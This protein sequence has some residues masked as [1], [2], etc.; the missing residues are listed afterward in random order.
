[1]KATDAVRQLYLQELNIEDAKDLSET[2]ITNLPNS[3]AAMR[4]A[5]SARKSDE[6]WLSAIHP[7]TAT[8]CSPLYSMKDETK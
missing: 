1:M 6:R 7:F 2:Q 5:R 4:A 8:T 3:G